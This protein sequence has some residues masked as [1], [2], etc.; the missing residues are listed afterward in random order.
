MSTTA[1]PMTSSPTSPQGDPPV[2]RS[3]G[4]AIGVA[5]LAFAVGVLAVPGDTTTTAAVAGVE[6]LL[7]AGALLPFIA[8]IASRMR[9]AGAPTAAAIALG[10]SGVAVAVKVATGAAGWAARDAALVA[11]AAHGL[12]RMNEIGFIAFLGPLGVAVAAIAAAS[13][14]GR[15]LPRWLGVGAAPVAVALMANSLLLDATFGPALLL[16]L[17]WTAVTSV[18]LLIKPGAPA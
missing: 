14:R 12:E 17:M 15:G 8:G 13:V 9:L 7:L 6:L 4:R 1:R 2:G 10:A 18:A 16:L 11:E 5:G 3:S